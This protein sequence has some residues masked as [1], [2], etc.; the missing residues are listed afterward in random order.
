[1]SKINHLNYNKKRV[2]V[3]GADGF[4]GSHL[5]ERLLIQGA[6]VTALACYN[7]FGT[8]GW[9]DDLPDS[10]RKSIN[11]K[12]GDIRD[13]N[14]MRELMEGYD[15][16]F[17][18]A[19]LIGIP[20]SY[21]A[22]QSYVDVNIHGTLN[23]LEMARVGSIGRIVHTST[24]EVYGSAQTKPITEKHPLNG[25][26][27]YAASKIGADQ[28]VKAYAL[29]HN[30]PAVILRPF[31]TYGPRQ[32]ERAVIPTVIRQILDI[33]CKEIR[34]G[35]VNTTRDFNFVEDTVHA[36]ATIGLAQNINYGEAYNTGT[37]IEISISKII[38]T[39]SELT[40][41]NKPVVTEKD[42]IRPKESE[43]KALVADSNKLQQ[44][45]GWKPSTSVD[46]GLEKTIDWWRPRISSGYI[47]KDSG[48]A[49]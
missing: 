36:F 48:Y 41:S 31:N 42:R 45:I 34:L 21:V 28:M 43:V 25:Q 33:S 13:S 3:T 22:A 37:G 30:T 10:S 1:M 32:S 24:S 38:T 26:S 14:Q 39:L 18:L 2:L 27:P 8:Y 11:I 5:V 6:E 20:Y 49:L 47:R 12:F 4:I 17:H 7:S 9:L 35:D 44:S 46:K 19:A 16:I 40:N 29:S 23:I 15:I